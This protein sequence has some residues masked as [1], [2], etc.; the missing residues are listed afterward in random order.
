MMVDATSVYDADRILFAKGLVA[1]QSPLDSV[2]ICMYVCALSVPYWG[3]A[4]LG[5]DIPVL[6]QV[7]EL[8][9]RGPTDHE[10]VSRY[11][12]L[13][14]ATDRVASVDDP[15]HTCQVGALPPSLPMHSLTMT[16]TIVYQATMSVRWSNILGALV[17]LT[18]FTSQ[19]SFLITK[20]FNSCC[21]NV[22]L[23]KSVR[24]W[25]KLY[26]Q[27]SFFKP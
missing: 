21:Q 7:T 2:C 12:I 20:R 25:G 24:W 26:S 19:S 18:E 10:G 17:H 5:G 3:I 9:L 13:I 15:G 8:R 1:K 6:L 27:T 11:D 23:V 16:L 22:W 4:C 14:I